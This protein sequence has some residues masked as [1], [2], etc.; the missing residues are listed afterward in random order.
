M[1]AGSGWPL[2]KARNGDW[3]EA[4]FQRAA[5]N[6]WEANAKQEAARI[7]QIAQSHRHGST[8]PQ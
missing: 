5:E 3:H 2:R 4:H 1:N 6:T 8:A 7:R